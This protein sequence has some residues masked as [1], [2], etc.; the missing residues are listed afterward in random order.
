[1]LE[2]AGMKKTS[3]PY[4]YD[5]I[6]ELAP[7]ETSPILLFRWDNLP[8][9]YSNNR[10]RSL[11]QTLSATFRLDWTI[12]ED[13][14]YNPNYSNFFKKT[15]ERNLVIRPSLDLSKKY[16]TFNL[17]DI[18]KGTLSIISDNEKIKDYNITVRKNSGKTYVYL[19]IMTRIG[20]KTF[21]SATPKEDKRTISEIKGEIRKDEKYS[22][23]WGFNGLFLPDFS[24]ESHNLYDFRYRLNIRG[25]VLYILAEIEFGKRH[26]GNRLN[27]M[28]MVLE[29]LSKNFV[30][31]FPFLLFYNDFKNALRGRSYYLPR[32]IS[33]V[34]LELQYQVYSADNRF[35]MYW[36]I[37]RFSEDLMK[38]LITPIVWDLWK[39]GNSAG[40][41]TNL[42]DKL[43]KYQLRTIS[44]LADY[45][46][47][48]YNYAEADRKELLDNRLVSRF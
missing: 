26:K 7:T 1:M 34:A 29:N 3:S 23:F 17:V 32:L 8:G 41:L 18:Q 12:S 43:K 21:L 13:P 16:L 45:H 2:K 36:V 42:D 48:E 9:E 20:P 30:E 11:L 28:N 25:L 47:D 44:L 27:Q 5:M 15:D 31:D 22:Q 46:R 39:G 40:N 14:K 10:L 37:K 6:G 19:N 24:R 35:L 33:E 4:V 38:N